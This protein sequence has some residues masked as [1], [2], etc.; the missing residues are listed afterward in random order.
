MAV[1]L[2][3]VV[4]QTPPVGRETQGLA[5]A[6]LDR[7][8]GGRHGKRRRGPL[9]RLEGG[10]RRRIRLQPG[11]ITG[12]GRIRL[13]LGKASVRPRQ[14]RRI[15]VQEIG[16]R[17]SVGPRPIRRVDQHAERKEHRRGQAE[18]Q[19]AER[20]WLPVRRAPAQSSGPAAGHDP[21]HRDRADHPLIPLIAIP[22]MK[23]RWAKKKTTTTG[24]ITTVLAAIR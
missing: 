5:N 13:H 16:R 3:G 15:A 17:T 1:G 10:H 22:S 20:G 6:R 24:V 2:E 12:K 4:E 18:H 14:C 8:R 9:L 11:W 23:V 19:H 21:P 7:A